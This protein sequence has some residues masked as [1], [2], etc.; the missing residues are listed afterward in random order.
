M[1]T[2][3]ATFLSVYVDDFRMAGEKQNL[4]PMWQKLGSKLYLEPAVPSS[5]NV[6]LGCLQNNV[7]VD[8]KIVKDKFEL[9]QR[10]IKGR[11]QPEASEESAE[12]DLMP[13]EQPK[14]KPKS[15]NKSSKKAS[16]AQ[17]NKFWAWVNDMKGHATQCVESY[18]ELANEPKSSLKQVATPCLDDHSFSAEDFESKGGFRTHRINK[19]IKVLYLAWLGRPDT[20]WA[21]N[22]QARE[23]TKW[24]IACDR[25]LHRLISYLNCTETG[26]KSVLWRIGWRIV[27]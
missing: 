25:R 2:E 18:L 17:E 13:K 8:P 27:G 1:S 12:G 15:K 10:L 24:N 19:K 23:V 20:L 26:C 9:F 4:K 14:P 7:D 5:G 22:T 16:P 3:N 6:Y 21:V 11:E